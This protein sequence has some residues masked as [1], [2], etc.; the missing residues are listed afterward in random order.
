MDI[1]VPAITTPKQITTHNFYPINPLSA[2]R[3]SES[4][5]PAKIDS[6]AA[7]HPAGL[8]YDYSTFTLL[9]NLSSISAAI[10]PTTRQITLTARWPGTVNPSNGMIIT[11]AA[12]TIPMIP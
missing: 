8:L 10:T 3:F 1:I 2:F 11:V 9:L 6:P 12:I 7:V 4:D 5:I